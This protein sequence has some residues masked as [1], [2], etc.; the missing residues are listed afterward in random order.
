MSISHNCNEI[1]QAIRF[2]SKTKNI[3]ETTRIPAAD[4]KPGMRG[5]QSAARRSSAK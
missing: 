1:S 4:K 5:Q 3:T 2:A